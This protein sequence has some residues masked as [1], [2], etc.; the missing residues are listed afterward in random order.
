MQL[1]SFEALFDSY[2]NLVFNV[3]LQY[4]PNAQDAEE[5]TQD[6]FVKVYEQLSRFRKESDI[7]TWI[8][9]IAITTAL[10][11]LKHR[12]RKKRFFLFNSK[13]I[14]HKDEHLY[15]SFEHPAIALEQKEQYQ[16]LFKCLDQLSDN[17]RTVLILLKIEQLSQKEVAT[18]L[19]I[20]EK[21][22]ESLLQRAKKNLE[23]KLKQQ[24]DF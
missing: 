1:P 14:E 19:D 17:Q 23:Q 16:L 7:R 10:D 21:A 6:V 12:Q 18:I 2:K 24:K 11:F 9:R 8:Y 22:V 13:S 3:V 4:V 20:S 15:A 5:I